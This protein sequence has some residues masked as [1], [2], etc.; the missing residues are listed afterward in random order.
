M[1]ITVIVLAACSTFWVLSVRNWNNR[2]R[3]ARQQFLTTHH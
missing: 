3:E 1:T 2:C